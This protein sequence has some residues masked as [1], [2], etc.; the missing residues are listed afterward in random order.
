MAAVYSSYEGRC[1]YYRLYRGNIPDIKT[2]DN[3]VDVSKAMGFHFRRI[4]LDRGYCS[5]NNLYRLTY[6]CNYKVIMCLKS[7]MRVF[8]EALR[9]VHG[10]FEE[11]CTYYLNDHNVYGKSICQEITLTSHDKK[12]IKPNIM[13]MCT[14]T[15]RKQQTRNLKFMKNG[16]IPL[17]S[18][19]EW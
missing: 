13:S 5:W 11:D 4:V 18:L 17:P 6:E 10:T 3:F 1:G 12:N 19:P 2:I 8:K 7:N 16:K 15:K 14:I 9:T